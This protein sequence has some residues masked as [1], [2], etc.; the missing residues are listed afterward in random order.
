M[1]YLVI[2]KQYAVSPFY[3]LWSLIDPKLQKLKYLLSSWQCIPIKCWEFEG[4][5]KSDFL[6]DCFIN[7]PVVCLLRIQWINVL[8]PFKLS[9]F[10]Y[11]LLNAI[12]SHFA[13]KLIYLISGALATFAFRQRN[14]VF[15][16]PSVNSLT[17]CLS[18]TCPFFSPTVTFNAII[19]G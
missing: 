10:N 6:S 19:S 12:P 17:L 3:T 13:E 5:K 1:L 16:L 2:I 4:Y 18:S 8:R 9:V 7:I 15:A 11:V 14:T